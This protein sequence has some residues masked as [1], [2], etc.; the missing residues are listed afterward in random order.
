[1]ARS[2]SLFLDEL[3]RE[4]E[5]LVELR[6][7]LAAARGEHARDDLLRRDLELA[8]E[9]RQRRVL[10]QALLDRP[11]A[12]RRDDPANAG[13]ARRLLEHLEGADVARAPDVRAAAELAR[14]AGAHADD[15]DAVA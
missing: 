12:R 5:G 14:E 9:L 11:G 8:R 13:R 7:I 15:S 4:R 10:L 1:M 3:P 6:G 2:A